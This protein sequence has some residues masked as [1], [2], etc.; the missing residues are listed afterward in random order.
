MGCA[1]CSFLK[2]CGHIFRDLN[3][4]EWL[5]CFTTTKYTK[6]IWASLCF[7]IQCSWNRTPNHLLLLQL[8]ERRP[9]TSRLVGLDIDGDLLE[10]KSRFLAPL[11]ADHV[12][13]NL[14]IIIWRWAVDPDPH[15]SAF[16]FP[17]TNNCIT[18][19]KVHLDQFQGFFYFWDTGI[20]FSTSSSSS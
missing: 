11:V 10:V 4:L 19:F 6:N 14:F 15:G 3:S 16:M 20:F 5:W 17:Y 8:L 13:K 9:G 1:E 12:G 18:I 2:V 7:S